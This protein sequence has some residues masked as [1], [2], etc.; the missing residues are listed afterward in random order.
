MRPLLV[1]NASGP[2]QLQDYPGGRLD[3]L[4]AGPYQVVVVPIPP[5]KGDVNEAVLPKAREI[6]AA[7]EQCDQACR[8]RRLSADLL[9]RRTQN[10]AARRS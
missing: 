1:G 4:A 7:L 10:V 3:Q 9:D 5:R 2:Y 8:K 6:Q